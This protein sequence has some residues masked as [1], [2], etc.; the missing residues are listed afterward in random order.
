MKRSEFLKII[1][2]FSLL[3][4]KSIWSKNQ[5]PK[6]LKKITI[7][8]TNDTHAQI[9]PFPEDHPKYAGLGGFSRR[10]SYVNKIRK[11]NK[12]V[13][14]L[15]SGD[16]F[17]GTPYFNFFKGK[18]DYQLMSQLKYD[19][20]TLGNHEFDNGVDGLFDAMQELKFPMVNSNYF[21]SDTRFENKIK[22]Y[23]I[24]E[25]NG[26]RIGIFGLGID[27]KSLVLESN[28]KGFTYREAIS[29]GKGVSSNLKK[30]LKC[31]YVVCLSHLGYDYPNEPRKPNDL[32]LAK[33]SEYIDMILG[34][35]THTFL[36]KPIL[37]QNKA[38]RDVLINQVGFAGIQ[39]GQI[40]L[41]FNEDNTLAYFD[42][43]TPQIS[44]N[45]A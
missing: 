21:I 32:R 19:A 16:V 5:N 2:A 22:N 25:I 12:H 45:L 42:S 17:Q 34:G 36:D 20:T 27:F 10:A 37:I 6:G 31:D 33:E 7:L 35:H 44:S 15:D 24:K 3:P 41:Y 26:I 29:V 9:D 8:H 40:D 1:G 11:I 39:I 13:L 23:L 43:S 38:G 4:D 28:H 14:L 18:L 30:Y